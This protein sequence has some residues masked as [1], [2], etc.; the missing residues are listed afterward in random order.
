VKF[1]RA[2]FNSGAKVLRFA[3]NDSKRELFNEKW[4]LKAIMNFAKHA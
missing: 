2:K 3:Q 1:V 4:L